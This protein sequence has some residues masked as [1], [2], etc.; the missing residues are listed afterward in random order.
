MA[1]N[2][3]DDGPV[4]SFHRR[5]TLFCSGGPFLDGFALTIIG[6]AFITMQPA[7]SLTPTQVGLVGSAAL[8]GIFVGGAVFGYLT[9]IVGRKVMY[10][11]DLLMLVITS[12]LSAFV[13]EAWQ[14]IVLRFLLGVAVG[15][16]YPIAS[17]LL[18][19]FLPRHSRG[20]YLGALFVVWGAGAFFAALV[21]WALSG[22]GADAWRYMLA[23][24][25]LIGLLTVIFRAGTP[26]SP[27]WLLSKGRTSEAASVLRQ[28]YGHHVDVSV[29]RQEPKPA[30]Y[31]RVFRAPYLSR[32]IFVSVFFS[33]HVIPLFAVYTFGPQ[34][35][36]SMGLPHGIGVY[37]AEAI[38]GALFLVG[39]I[40]GLLLVDRVGRRKL[41]L[42]TFLIMAAA[43]G[44]IGM[45]SDAP[46]VFLLVMLGLYAVVSGSCNFIEIIYPNE[47]FPTEIRA[48][49]TGVVTAASRI[50][51]AVSTFFLPVVLVQ[52]GMAAT[53]MFLAAVNLVG[54][55][56]T[57]TLGVETNGRPL[58]ET[59]E[60]GAAPGTSPEYVGGQA[61]GLRE[62]RLTSK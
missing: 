10:V 27:R 35:L 36:E 39:G 18:V 15:A 34:I 28:V 33:A 56:V 21:G 29:I 46:P 59:S 53:M 42:W 45:F 43:F 22:L 16:D 41:L 50:G 24:P 5:L 40:P 2:V 26:E 57:V 58:D 6:L 60:A 47:L 20:R 55:L 19:E 9:D 51:A 4:T 31:S 38:I 32:T 25:A 7:L 62:I 44:V 52:Y 49:A 14:L 61:Q 13:T 12:L 23:S 48:T 1:I 37:L 3:I 11:A 54:W 30:S 17:S 8:A